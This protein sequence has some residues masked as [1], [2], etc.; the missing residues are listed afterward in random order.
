MYLN[1]VSFVQIVI[2]LN[3]LIMQILYNT[4]QTGTIFSEPLVLIAFYVKILAQLLSHHYELYF[5]STL[6]SNG[7]SITISYLRIRFTFLTLIN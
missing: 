5:G 7:V 1:L 3:Y 4:I 2:T 6:G